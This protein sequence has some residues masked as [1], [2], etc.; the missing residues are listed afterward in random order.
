MIQP[1]NTTQR[2]TLT[3][4]G[5]EMKNNEWPMAPDDKLT[6][7]LALVITMCIISLIFCN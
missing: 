1:A 4:G 3:I 5:G 2:V 7:F 6:V